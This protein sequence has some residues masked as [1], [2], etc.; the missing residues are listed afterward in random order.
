MKRPLFLLVDPDEAFGTAVQEACQARVGD[1]LECVY[2]PDI[3]AAFAVLQMITSE[4]REIAIV[5]TALELPNQQGPEMLVQVHQSHPETYTMLLSETFEMGALQRAINDGRL[6]RWL[7]KPIAP[8]EMVLQVARALSRYQQQRQNTERGAL[9]TSMN[10]AISE[11]TAEI[12]SRRIVAKFLSLIIDNTR[13][14]QGFFIQSRQG[15]LRVEGIGALDRDQQRR[16]RRQFDDHRQTEEAAIIARMTEAIQAE[17]D[18]TNAPL[19]VYPISKK[20]KMLGYL[21]LENPASGEPFTAAHYD[22]LNLLSGQTAIALENAQLYESLED[23]NQEVQREKEKVEAVKETLEERNKDIMDSIR[24]AKRL[25]RTILPDRSILQSQFPDSFVYYRPKE[26]IGGDFYWYAERLHKFLIA[27]VDCTGHG[28]PGA[29][30]SIISGNLLNQ[31]MGDYAMQAPHNLLYKLN[32]SIRKALR[33]DQEDSET[34]DGM[35]LALCSID[36]EEQTIQF[37]NAHRPLYLVFEGQLTEYKGSRYSI[38]GQIQ[39]EEEEMFTTQLIQY[40][41]GTM[42]YLFSDGIVDQFGGENEQRFTTRR[43]KEALTQI[44]PLS[45]PDQQNEL[46]RILDEWRGPAEQTDDILVVGVRL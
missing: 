1:E 17:T 4:R 22:I 45:G 21:F 31:L 12:D 19:V 14:E 44:S 3:E 28:V 39:T 35:D 20:G 34:N 25:Q 7:H 38:G 42:L 18:S 32:E 9:F 43:L 6:Y 41:R 30:M 29:F 2:L 24:Y 8:A 27:A 33:Q 40:E 36:T 37:A 11:I 46:E 13:A 5:A 26:I 15:K 10:R 23:K 16:M